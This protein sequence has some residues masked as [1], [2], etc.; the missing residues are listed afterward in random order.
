M[1]DYEKCG[2]KLNSLVSELREISVEKLNK[3]LTSIAADVIEQLSEE[4]DAAVKDFKET[5]QCGLFSNCYY[6]K[7]RMT[8][9]CK[10]CGEA[11]E[12]WEWRGAQK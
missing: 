4:R 8:Q 3:Q 9:K 10:N 12:N 5:L 2:L 6:C 11:V 7:N 1:I